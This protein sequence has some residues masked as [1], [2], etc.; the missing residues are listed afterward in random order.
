MRRG[1]WGSGLLEELQG[2]GDLEGVRG[3]LR[4]SRILRMIERLLGAL[5]EDFR[6]FDQVRDQDAGGIGV[7]MSAD[8][9]ARET[10]LIR[11]LQVIEQRLEM[12]GQFLPEGG[13]TLL[14]PGDVDAGAA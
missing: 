2:N 11:V 13:N 6:L 3:A 10:G 8:R 9:P 4:G 12:L 7:H 1:W 5:Q 14:I